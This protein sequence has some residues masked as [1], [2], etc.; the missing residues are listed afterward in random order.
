MHSSGFQS[1]GLGWAYLQ[2]RL[3]LPHHGLGTRRRFDPAA[4]ELLDEFGSIGFKAEAP[5]NDRR[6]PADQSRLSIPLEGDSKQASDLPPARPHGGS[7]ARSM[8]VVA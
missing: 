6:L 8:I 5:E 1:R 2:S 7:S 3:S 4:D